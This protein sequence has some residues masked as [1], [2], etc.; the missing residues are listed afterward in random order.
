MTSLDGR[1][2]RR[3]ALF[4]FGG[5]LLLTP[6]ELNGLAEAS[7]GVPA[8]SLPRGPFDPD[9]D[10]RWKAWQA[11]EITERQY[12]AERAAPLGLDVIGY[13]RHFFEP[14]G[15]H[16]IR[17]EMA[18]VVEAV[19]AAGYRAGLLTN[20][21]SAFHGPEWRE[22]I[23]VLQ[24]VDPLVDL[25]MT[26]HLKPHPRAYESAIEAMGVPADEIVFI[27]DQRANVDGGA[28]AGLRT[29]WF[30]PTDASS[31]IGRL[32]DSLTGE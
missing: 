25:S 4:D 15:N 17:M 1:T 3:H 2:I 29:V 22:P 6:F 32:V 14:S 10:P 7:L 28:R 12:W 9:G 8:G 23:D 5:P 21:L 31:S 24:R 13:M 19:Q 26:G 16:L 20:D 30:D 27:D 18:S 11:E